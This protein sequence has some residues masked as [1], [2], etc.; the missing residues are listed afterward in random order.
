LQPEQQQ[1]KQE[2]ARLALS[3]ANLFE[4]AVILLSNKNFPGRAVLLAH[5]VRELGNSLPDF[6]EE[7]SDTRLFQWVQRL[8]DLQ[9]DWDTSGMARYDQPADAL[10]GSEPPEIPMPR[11]LYTRIRNILKDFEASDERRKDKVVRMFRNMAPDLLTRR[12]AKSS[13]VIEWLET[14]DW[15]VEITHHRRGKEVSDIREDDLQ[16]RFTTFENILRLLLPKIALVLALDKID[17]ILHEANQ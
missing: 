17:E 15:F 8:R 10:P 13:V 6:L 14:I 12:A 11:N 1:I 16:V 3:L 2:L 4:A 7:P 9:K 5:A